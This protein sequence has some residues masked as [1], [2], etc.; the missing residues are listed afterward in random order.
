M[1]SRFGITAVFHYAP[2]H[3]LAFIARRSALLSKNA[4]R[5]EGFEDAHFRS[6]SAAQDDQRGFSRY[7]HL[8]P[9]AHPPI[10]RAK[11]SRGFPHFEVAVPAEQLEQLGY[12][13]CRFNIAK[14]RYFR[15][16]KTEPPESDK[17]G[18]YYEGMRLPVAKTAHERRL[19]LQLNYGKCMIEVLV[20]DLLPLG[21]G[22]SFRFFDEGD[23]ATA[24]DVL[25]RLDV[26]AY[27]LQMDKQMKYKP[28]P[29]HQRDVRDALARAVEDARWRGNGLDFDKL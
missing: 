25:A 20:A 10:L 24:K 3:Y 7:V 14:T 8:T 12:L 9:E 16:A 13:L 27:D 23:L 1:L 18:R 11:L 2:L 19:M 26:S 17:N 28:A 22:V 5:H 21:H 29:K 4:L 15:G 6:T